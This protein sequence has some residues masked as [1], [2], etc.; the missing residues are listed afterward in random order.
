MTPPDT[1]TPWLAGG[2]GCYL[3]LSATGVLAQSKA[4]EEFVQGLRTNRVITH[5]TGAVAFF[6]GGIILLLTPGFGSWLA[7]LLSLTALW[8]I[9]E[10][11]LMLAAP[12]IALGRSDAGRHFRHMNMLALP[13]GL[14]LAV[15]AILHLA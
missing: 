1:L 14:A 15:G 13:V 9:V 11:A 10:G 8:W 3:L 5:L 12:T 2:V 7:A 6:V 4:A